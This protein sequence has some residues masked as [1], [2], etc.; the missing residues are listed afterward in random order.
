VL[1][2][3]GHARP[4]D[5]GRLSLILQGWLQRRRWRGAGKAV[6]RGKRLAGTR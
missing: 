1:R 6:Q 5:T 3:S 2:L 4:S